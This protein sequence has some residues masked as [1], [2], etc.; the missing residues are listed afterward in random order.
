[1]ER[2]DTCHCSLPSQALCFRGRAACLTWWESFIE[3][4]LRFSF[5][6]VYF[7]RRVH[8]VT[9]TSGF[10]SVG[11]NLQRFHLLVESAR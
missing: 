11:E 5:E 3:P 4:I 9:G 8:E 7:Q 2:D 10:G 1:M 6:S